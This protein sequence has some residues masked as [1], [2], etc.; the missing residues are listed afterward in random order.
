MKTSTYPQY[1]DL[2]TCYYSTIQASCW[3]SYY[4]TPTNTT[5]IMIILQ[6]LYCLKE[7]MVRY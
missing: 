3:S 5:V 2:S 1:S 6:I 4:L 7:A